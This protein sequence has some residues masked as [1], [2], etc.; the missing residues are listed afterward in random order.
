[1][2]KRVSTSASLMSFLTARFLWPCGMQ[3]TE[4][5]RRVK[6]IDFSV[7]YAIVFRE[8]DV[9]QWTGPRVKMRLRMQLASPTSANV[10]REIFRQRYRYSDLFL[11]V[12]LESLNNLIQGKRAAFLEPDDRADLR[13]DTLW[14]CYSSNVLLASRFPRRVE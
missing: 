9:K 2:P 7:K 4:F 3:C 14:I 8:K 6:S 10:A 12:M 1:M 5:E 13:E 11:S